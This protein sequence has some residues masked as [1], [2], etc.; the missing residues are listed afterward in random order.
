MKSIADI[1]IE[2]SL[3]LS[4]KVWILFRML[5]CLHLLCPQMFWSALI[6]SV[7]VSPDPFCVCQPWSILCLS[8][9]LC[10][11]FVSFAL[12]CVCQPCT[13]LCLSVLLCSVFVSPALFCVCQFCSV[14]C[15]SVLLCSGVYS[16]L[17]CSAVVLFLYTHY[18]FYSIAQRI[19]ALSWQNMASAKNKKT[20]C[21]RG[22]QQKH[23]KMTP[24][25]TI[26][27]EQSE[28]TADEK[29]LLPK[30]HLARNAHMCKN[31]TNTQDAPCEK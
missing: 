20:T 21:E 12:F 10:S 31:L 26:F 30:M 16:Y 4:N 24:H 8:V 11:V 19:C 27:V 1:S 22:K 15:L 3:S 18:K 14:L 5:C 29:I 28:T 13:V 6:H 25:L 17:A 2:Q 23:K 7:F 9:L